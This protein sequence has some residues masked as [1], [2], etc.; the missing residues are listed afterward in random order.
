MDTLEQLVRCAQSLS[1]GLLIGLERERHG[2]TLAGLRT[3]GLIALAG[4]LSSFLA[5]Q[6][7]SPWIIGAAL[8]VL[9]G[10]IAAT[11]IRHAAPG[12]D[13]GT[14]SVAAAVVT[15][16]LGAMSWAGFAELAVSLGVATT[17]LLYFRTELHGAIQKL[18][19]SD[20]VS[21]L[22]VSVLA[23]VVLPLLPDHAYGPYGVLNPYRMGLLVVLVT[24]LSLSGYLALQ[25]LPARFGLPLLGLAG[26]LV[27]TTATTMTFSRHARADASRQHLVIMVILLSNMVLFFRLST[28]AA[29][30]SQGIFFAMAPAL[31]AGATTAAVY[32][33][34]CWRRTPQGTVLPTLTLENPAQLQAALSLA[35]MFVGIQLAVAWLVDHAGSPG[36]YGGAVLAGLT[37]LDAITLSSLRLF[38]AGQITE[39]QTVTAI[40][41]AYW[42]NLMFKLG[43]VAV[44]GTRVVLRFVAG[45]FLCGA[46][47]MLG[48]WLLGRI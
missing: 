37:D 29:V 8:L 48:V 36:F 7:N 30:V 3:F 41:I 34:W 1:I 32:V 46:V 20:M 43:I 21:L 14:T 40:L 2:D 39:T 25:L 22:Q 15:F 42:S 5:T 26:G 33:A 19:Q 10:S 47:V 35:A 31:V 13:P 45:G 11:Y 4:A 12:V 38:N 44:V 23:F 27:S 17:A 16:I 24:A 9:S 18:S 6:F 28:L